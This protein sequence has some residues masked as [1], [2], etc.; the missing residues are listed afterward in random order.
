MIF[1]ALSSSR[2]PFIISPTCHEHQ[3]LL[4]YGHSEGKATFFVLSCEAPF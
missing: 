3:K 1:F 4:P 2:L